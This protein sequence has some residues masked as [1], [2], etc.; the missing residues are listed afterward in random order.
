MAAAGKFG[1]ARLWILPGQTGY[2]GQISVFKQQ[3]LQGRDA[4]QVARREM[5]RGSTNQS[6]QVSRFGLHREDFALNSRTR[7]SREISER[8]TNN[9]TKPTVLVHA[10]RDGRSVCILPISRSRALNIHGTMPFAYDVPP[11][12]G[13]IG[14]LY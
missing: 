12:P 3:A 9:I 6:G 13:V 14:T 2:H 4:F 10:R 8:R 7:A 5:A 1:R 11:Y